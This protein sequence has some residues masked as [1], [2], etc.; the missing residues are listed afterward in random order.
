MLKLRHDEFAYQKSSNSLV[1]EEPNSTQYQY[2]FARKIGNHTYRNTPWMRCM[3]Y[4]N[5]CLEWAKGNLTRNGAYRLNYHKE[6]WELDSLD[7]LRLIIGHS[8]EEHIEMDWEFIRVFFTI[9][10]GG[11]RLNQ[12]AQSVVYEDPGPEQWEGSPD[13]IY[14]RTVKPDP[15][16]WKARVGLAIFLRC[17]RSGEWIKQ[18]DRDSLMETPTLENAYRLFNRTNKSFSVDNVWM[19]PLFKGSLADVQARVD[20][21]YD[22]IKHERDPDYGCVDTLHEEGISRFLLVLKYGEDSDDY[23]EHDEMYDGDSW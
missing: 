22:T 2:A 23:D 8:K 18:A 10:S 6:A 16:V 11:H 9:L 20:A 12:M 21:L 15:V 1:Q 14:C 5:E 7:D 13:K 4:G 19:L 17:L 3:E